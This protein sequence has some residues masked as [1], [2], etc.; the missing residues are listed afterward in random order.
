[1]QA[2]RD[3][4]IRFVF[5][6]LREELLPRR[7][8]LIDVDLRWGVTNEQ[9]ASEVCREL[10]DECQPRF[11]CMLGGRYGTVPPAKTLSITD[12]EVRHAIFNSTFDRRFTTIYFRDE[13][14]TAQMVESFPGEFREPEGSD[15]QRK[16]TQLKQTIIAS[17][18]PFIYSPKWHNADRRLVELD[19]FGHQVFADLKRGIDVEFGEA[20]SEQPGE[21]E[22]ENASMEA[23]VEERS[24]RFV[25]GSR[26]PVFN[27]LLAYTGNGVTNG[28]ICLTG[29]S[30][31]GK[32]SMLAYLS[33]HLTLKP[34]EST[35]LIRHFVGASPGSADMRRTLRRLCYELKAGCPDITTAIPDDLEQLGAALPDFLSQASEQRT[36]VIIIDAINQMDEI[37]HL[38]DLGWL[39]KSIPPRARIILSMP[40]GP[41]LVKLRQRITG[42]RIIE[43]APLTADDGEAIINQ[44]FSRFGKRVRQD[45]R[46]A[47]LAKEEAGT[48][49]YL[50]AAL[51]ELRTLGV[52]EE[53][54]RRIAELP[55]TTHELFL[56]I[57][58]RLESDDGFRNAEG[59]RDGAQLVSE[60]AALLVASRRGLSERELVDLLTPD[61]STT[62]FSEKSDSQGNVATL[63]Y[64]LRPYLMRRG[65]QLDFYHSQ[66]RQVAETQYFCEEQTRLRAHRT[67]SS[68]FHLKTKPLDLTRSTDD[69]SRAL[70]ELPH[71][72]ICG[73]SWQEL[74]QTICDLAFLEAKASA[75]MTFE[76]MEDFNEAI[77][78]IPQS[79]PAIET[80]RALGAALGQHA[81]YIARSPSQLFQSLW[82]TCWWEGSSQLRYFVGDM[83]NAAGALSQTSAARAL[84]SLMES[85][86]AAKQSR[87]P[88]FVWVR[89]LCPSF[90]TD[91][92][93]KV[94]IPFADDDRPAALHFSSDQS[95]LIVWFCSYARG[96]IANSRPR[97]FDC[98]TGR[99][100]KYIDAT[101]FQFSDPKSSQ[102]GTLVAAFGGEGGGWGHP[103]KVI[104]VKTTQLRCQL[105]IDD[106]TNI[107]A[108]CFS[109]DNKYLA[110]GGY[111]V[112]SC[113]LV[114][115]WEIETKKLVR[116]IEPTSRSDYVWSVAFFPDGKQLVLGTLGG[117]IF[118]WNLAD[119][120]HL[121]LPTHQAGIIAATVS[122]DGK[123]VASTSDDGTIRISSSEKGTTSKDLAKHPDSIVEV[124]F[125]LTGERLIT[126]SENG[127]AW[128][129]NGTTGVP[130][131]CLRRNTGFVLEGGPARKCVF[132][133]EREIISVDN[134][135]GGIWKADTGELIRSGFSGRLFSADNVAF[136]PNG[137]AFASWRSGHGDGKR[138][139]SSDSIT[140]K[141]IFEE[142]HGDDVS[143]VSFSSGS[144]YLASGTE[145]GIVAIFDVAV[146]RKLI[147]FPAHKGI[148]SAI[149]FSQDNTFIATTGTDN[150]VCIWLWRSAE[151]TIAIGINNPSVWKQWTEWKADVGGTHYEFRAVS[152]LVFLKDGDWVAAR[153]DSNQINIWDRS[154]GTLQ[155]S[156][157]TGM[158]LGELARGVSTY[159]TVLEDEINIIDATREKTIARFPVRKGLG[160]GLALIPHPSGRIWAGALRNHIYHI[161][162]EG[163]VRDVPDRF[164]LACTDLR[165]I[166]TESAT[167][168]FERSRDLSSA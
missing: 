6:R 68:Y 93:L 20:P 24:E 155:K 65:K 120:S 129:W 36:V 50:L 31:S 157:S 58:R 40:E 104:D 3:H 71:H 114:L 26:A 90:D 149:T 56:W 145:G 77:R 142:L 153:I 80:V 164:G 15:S 151:K 98:S 109:A 69:R 59:V 156:L 134:E 27:E 119:G 79:L 74:E 55:R 158:S 9:D 29:A 49:L 96:E 148:I 51:E 112:N 39:P 166:D 118:V 86:R 140:G 57:F 33:R 25:L 125:S 102:D 100:N 64:L 34:Q 107:Q 75:N 89:S 106:D 152:D 110:A 108:T 53:L 28:Y 41:A 61:S 94:I 67:L 101:L 85:W 87:F 78:S 139:F 144:A 5:P 73:H 62:Q 45:Q 18:Q 154:K 141:I 54:S 92:R 16:L 132:A 32:S 128:L 8:H 30:G 17:L 162:L 103:V 117:Q 11:L 127:T 46:M 66:F 82:N 124:A 14:S 52:H 63:L 37:T 81:T 113:G 163:N 111:D 1:M 88:G 131:F 146:G 99:E 72:Q 44:F 133:D 76:L 135:N 47:L 60:F 38:V 4:L 22:E 122:S 147:E 95:Q 130:I 13:A 126:R 84:S 21:F 7:I 143:C 121:E 83:Q 161:T 35:M 70:A 10:I 19:G 138:L 48:P 116:K 137:R 123:L 43:L 2:E 159:A 150:V 136:S 165:T 23:F 115:V 97:L 91:P 105:E 168:K 160:G 12:E 167:L 42:L